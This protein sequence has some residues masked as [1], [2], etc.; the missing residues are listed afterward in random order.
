MSAYPDSRARTEG[1]DE[2]LQAEPGAVAITRAAVPINGDGTVDTAALM[3][4][5]NG[6]Q[7]QLLETIGTIEDGE[8]LR[9]AIGEYLSL[10]APRDLLRSVLAY[11]IEASAPDLSALLRIGKRVEL[12]GVVIPEMGAES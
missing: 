10:G 12:V 2:E 7:S 11:K 8:T 4:T 6:L 3:Q 9:N 5:R 1:P